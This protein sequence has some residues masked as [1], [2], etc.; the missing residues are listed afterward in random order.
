MPQSALDLT[1]RTE[2]ASLLYKL[3]I[4]MQKVS[5]RPLDP[6]QAAGAINDAL[7]GSLGQLRAHFS[8]PPEVVRGEAP[9]LAKAVAARTF[10][11]G[12]GPGIRLDMFFGPLHLVET[13][14]GLGVV[15]SETTKNP[16]SNT[17][18]DGKLETVDTLESLFPSKFG[19]MSHKI[20][21]ITA[22]V[23]ER[24]DLQYKI[25]RKF[26]NG[27]RV[28]AIIDRET[29]KPAYYAL[30]AAV[31]QDADDPYRE[32]IFTS[33]TEATKILN[34]LTRGTSHKSRSLPKF[35]EYLV[36]VKYSA[37]YLKNHPAGQVGSGMF[38]ALDGMLPSEDSSRQEESES[39]LQNALQEQRAKEEM[40]KRRKVEQ[41][42]S[43]RQREF[44]VARRRR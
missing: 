22:D 40:E 3:A 38:E 36:Y 1:D 20:K 17:G 5:K 10:V 12:H 2:V 13:V 15:T 26:E 41:E 28:W 23:R 9:T 30:P 39:R 32:A 25:E 14:E 33:A 8:P 44:D 43:S 29:G 34:D 6:A 35:K 37:V 21:V 27:K 16:V 4:R 18:F 19:G 42:Q 7:S 24:Q 11:P 31:A